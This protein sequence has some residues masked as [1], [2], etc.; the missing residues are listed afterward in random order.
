[1]MYD[2]SMSRF[3]LIHLTI[4]IP[5][6]YYYTLYGHIS[7]LHVMLVIECGKLVPDRM[8]VI[9]SSHQIGKAIKGNT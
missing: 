4:T 1:M 7:N 6:A 3:N 8:M 2:A 5:I 9:I